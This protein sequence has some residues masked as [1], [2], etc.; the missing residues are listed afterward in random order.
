MRKRDHMKNSKL[1]TI[2][3]VM[4]LLIGV[5][6]YTYSKWS[7]KSEQTTTNVFGTECLDTSLTESSGISLTNYYPVTDAEGLGGT[8]YTFSIKNICGQ[9]QDVQINLE[10]FSTSSSFTASQI[11]YSFNDSAADYINSMETMTPVITDATNGFILATDTISPDITHEYN[12][13]L[14][15]DENLTT[16]NANNKNFQSRISIITTYGK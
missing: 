1:I 9:V 11:R 5:I 4:I 2:F 15:I 7:I 3:I 16:E 12:L 13:K 10:V 8:P 14:W 6:G